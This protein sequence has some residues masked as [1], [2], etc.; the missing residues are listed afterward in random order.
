VVYAISHA[1]AGAGAAPW[2]EVAAAMPDAVEL[3]GLRLPGRENRFRTPAHTSMASAVAELR[4]IVE[5]D[6]ADH[7]KSVALAGSCSGALVAVTLTGALALPLAGLVAV[8]QPVPDNV[9]SAG[10][11]AS[12]DGGALRQWVHEHRITPGALL[13]SGA[14]EF[15]EPVL[16]ADVSVVEDYYY[17]GPVRHMPVHLVHCPWGGAEPES[18]AWRRVTDGPVECTYLDVE[19]DPLTEHPVELAAAIA[20]STADVPPTHSSGGSPVP[21]RNR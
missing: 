8:R 10:D 15:F 1:G 17:T 2:N 18:E 5:R 11:P 9:G 12:M 13:D 20:R 21:G 14:F 16:H 3:R 7:G 19:G 6:A 4:E